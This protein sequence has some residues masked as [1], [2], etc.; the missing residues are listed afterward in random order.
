MILN[1]KLYRFNSLLTVVLIVLGSFISASLADYLALIFIFTAGLIHGAND[2]SLLQKK[3]QNTRF[4][5]FISL[6]F[7]Y[8]LIVILG[9][10]LFFYIPSGALMFFIL[11]SGFHFGQQHWSSYFNR[12]SK[13]SLFKQLG[14][15]VYGLLI[16]SLL[17]S[18]QLS[19]VNS[20]IK[21]ITGFEFSTEFYYYCTLLLT[22]SFCILSFFLP[23]SLKVFFKEVL[24]LLL[25]SALF[26]STSLL[27]SFAVYFV[28]WHSVSSIQDQLI[29]L[30]GEVTLKT[31]LG[32]IKSSLVYW[33]LSLIGLFLFSFYMDIQSE[34]F[35]PLF[36]TFLA[37]ITFPHTVV[38]G[39][40]KSE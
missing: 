4:K 26:W 35:I 18:L 38:I 11:F 30:D 36:F 1:R 33:V 3:Y 10:V 8:I 12:N 13:D 14:F 32:Y 27:F 19:D 16:F 34:Y 17:F 39:M 21:D 31:V 2:I 20:V 40:L 37:A 29:Y 9:A 25:L 15:T 5:F 23:I 24:S 6:L 22:L 7:L 28:F